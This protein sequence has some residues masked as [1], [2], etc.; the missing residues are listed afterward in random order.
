MSKSAA[1][2]IIDYVGPLLA[3]KPRQRFRR[4]PC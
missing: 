3:L 1:D 2:R 4:T